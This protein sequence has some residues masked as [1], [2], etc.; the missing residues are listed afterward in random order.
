MPRA[1]TKK[2][3]PV[4]KSSSRTIPDLKVLKDLS[5]QLLTP[6]QFEAVTKVNY[7]HPDSRVVL[8]LFLHANYV[9]QIA[10]KLQNDPALVDSFD[11]AT[12]EKNSGKLVNETLAKLLTGIDPSSW[13]GNQPV[14]AKGS[15]PVRGTPRP[16]AKSRLA[17]GCKY[18]SDAAG[19]VEA[20]QLG[21]MQGADEA[22]W[23]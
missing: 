23:F 17:C 5:E 22:L 6:E 3:V 1:T 20:C 21:Q 13:T 15:K 18:H 14:P 10:R 2:T 16:K 9:W 19:V 4:K 12:I 8:H 7:H 11:W